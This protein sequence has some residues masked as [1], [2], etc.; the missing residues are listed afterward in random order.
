VGFAFHVEEGS[1]NGI[2]LDGLNFVAAFYT[3]AP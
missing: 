1:F 2:S 3:P